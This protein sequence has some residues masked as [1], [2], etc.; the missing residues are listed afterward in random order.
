MELFVRLV[1]SPQH[2]PHERTGTG[3]QLHPQREI[4]V[5]QDLDDLV[6][7]VLLGQR[8][9]LEQSDGVQVQVRDEEILVV[10]AE[11]MKGVN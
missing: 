9:E 5:A 2:G 3:H 1:K 6:F 11:L 10:V 8:Q 7:E 4:V